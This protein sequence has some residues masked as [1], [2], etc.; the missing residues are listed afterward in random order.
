MSCESRART[1]SERDVHPGGL[2]AQKQATAN[3]LATACFVG[4]GDRI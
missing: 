4:G 3:F 2:E 1:G